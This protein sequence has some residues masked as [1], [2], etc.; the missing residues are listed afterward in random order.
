V[1]AT[2]PVSGIMAFAIWI[3]WPQEPEITTGRIN[4]MPAMSRMEK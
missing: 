4:A 3:S 2:L 1:A